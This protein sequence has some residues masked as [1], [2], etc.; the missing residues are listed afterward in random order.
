ME[1]QHYANGNKL[2]VGDKI[3]YGFIMNYANLNGEPPTTYKE[4]DIS[5][6]LQLFVTKNNIIY[7]LYN[8]QN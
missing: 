3:N 2:M 8:K 6:S 7:Q 5:L 1:C 4:S